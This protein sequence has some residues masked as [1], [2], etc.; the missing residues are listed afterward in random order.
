MSLVSFFVILK[1][2]RG[3]SVK[4]DV[5]QVTETGMSQQKQQLLLFLLFPA[6]VLGEEFGEPLRC[7]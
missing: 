6:V 1:Q 2:N 5:C 4:R 7:Q 3:D